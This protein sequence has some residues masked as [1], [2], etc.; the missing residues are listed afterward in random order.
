MTTLILKQKASGIPLL[1]KLQAM[2][3]VINGWFERHHQRKQLARLEPRMLRDIGLDAEQVQAEI[4][5]P[6]WK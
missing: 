1:Q 5:K 2:L 4:R 3:A 6:F